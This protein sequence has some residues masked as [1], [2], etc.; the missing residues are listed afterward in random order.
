MNN[1]LNLEEADLERANSQKVISMSQLSPQKKPTVRNL[2]IPKIPW[3]GDIGSLPRLLRQVLLGRH[4][5]LESC[6]VLPLRAHPSQ[7]IQ[8]SNLRFSC[9]SFLPAW[10]SPLPNRRP[11]FYCC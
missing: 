4:V 11:Q 7:I 5:N 9:V 2:R 6:A 10:L 3:S 1:V 8:L